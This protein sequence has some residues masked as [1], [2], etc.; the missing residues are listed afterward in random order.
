[1]N[2]F[3]FF[4]RLPIQF[5]EEFVAMKRLSKAL[6][7]ITCLIILSV[8]SCSTTPDLTELDS[9]F[10][11]VTLFETESQELPVLYKPQ[12]CYGSDG[13]LLVF[14]GD[15]YIAVSQNGGESWKH[16]AFLNQRLS[17][18]STR[19]GTYDTIDCNRIA[20]Q[21]QMILIFSSHSGNIAAL[22]LD[23]GEHWVFHT[24]RDGK[25]F[26]MAS[27][28]TDVF[29]SPK[30]FYG[31]NIIFRSQYGAALW[32]PKHNNVPLLIEP[33]FEARFLKLNEKYIT[34]IATD[35]SG[36]AFYDISDSSWQ[37]IKQ[38]ESGLSG[39][40]RTALRNENIIIVGGMTGMFISHDQGDSFQNIA[41]SADFPDGWYPW[42]IGKVD[43]DSVIM[44]L[45]RKHPGENINNTW[46]IQDR[47]VENQGFYAFSEDRGVSWEVKA[48]HY[49]E[50]VDLLRQMNNS[51]PGK[52]LQVV[53]YDIPDPIKTG[54]EKIDGK[55]VLFRSAPL[56]KSY[57][58]ERSLDMGQSW[59][60][61]DDN[62]KYYGRDRSIDGRHTEIS[63]DGGQSWNDVKFNFEKADH[64]R[65]YDTPTYEDFLFAAYYSDGLLDRSNTQKYFDLLD[66]VYL[67]F[68]MRFIP[69]IYSDIC[70]QND[71]VLVKSR[72]GLY[73]SQDFGFTFKK[74]DSLP[75]PLNEIG[76][77]YFEGD[78]IFL[79]GYSGYVSRDRGESWQ[80]IE[81]PVNLINEARNTGAENGI[82]FTPDK[83]DIYEEG[84]AVYGF[85]RK[86]GDFPYIAIFRKDR[87]GPGSDSWQPVGKVVKPINNGY[88]TAINGD[89]IVI[90]YLGKY[91]SE[92]GEPY[93]SIFPMHM[94]TDRGM[95]WAKLELTDFVEKKTLLDAVSAEDFSLY[96][97]DNGILLGTDKGIYKVSFNGI[98]NE[99]P[100]ELGKRQNS[101]VVVSGKI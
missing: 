28:N 61:Y 20:F 45:Q 101:S 6:S 31:E 48:Y 7:S 55:P 96:P 29:F 72:D 49:P 16:T 14:A 4:R 51:S 91:H 69:H 87:V 10:K 5:P 13:D 99:A 62:F 81:I 78:A 25:A 73:L 52:Q 74:I 11:F 33:P 34:F 98:D 39:N 41:E 47:I 12:S 59:E 43:G 92:N 95:T 67:E 93:R 40:I 57:P 58:F 9:P 30:G 63:R 37:I 44:N 64:S 84:N 46:G 17:M 89:N 82:G 97:I 77:F 8:L 54:V 22:S 23:R 50:D 56:D 80:P 35:F 1:M 2:K 18:S 70:M 36:V 86:D 79:R 27:F 53:S 60:R 15:Q 65:I 100:V 90:L 24:T 3:A 94:S 32:N 85:F 75:V 21:D 38:E 66:R 71:Q 42:V 83:I 26:G 76:L 68:N 19:F 88:V